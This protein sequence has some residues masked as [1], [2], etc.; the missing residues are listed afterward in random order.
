MD[1]W[2]QIFIGLIAVI[3]T[4][5]ITRFI[6]E[7]TFPPMVRVRDAWIARFNTSGWAELAICPFCVSVYISAGTIATGLLL[8]F[9]PL[10]VV[11]Y[12]WLSLAYAA[13]ILV[14]RDIP[15]GE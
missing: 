14:A 6:T 5:R 11:I 7:D 15:N 3:G 9:G 8:D 10:W 1:I 12:S 4:A 2:E 13:A